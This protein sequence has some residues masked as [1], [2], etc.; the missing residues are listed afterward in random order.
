MNWKFKPQSHESDRN[1]LAW[2]IMKGTV[3]ADDMTRDNMKWELGIRGRRLKGRKEPHKMKNKFDGMPALARAF[4]CQGYVVPA[5]FYNDFSL[6]LKSILFIK[7]KTKLFQLK[8]SLLESK[9]KK[10]CFEV[11]QLFWIVGTSKK[12]FFLI[13][14]F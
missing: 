10:N 1:T 3:N 8:H 4:S 11:Q 9:R 14:N 12:A 2:H 6:K 7:Q 5:P 13:Q